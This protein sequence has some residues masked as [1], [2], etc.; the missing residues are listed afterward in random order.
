M[1]AVPQSL[2]DLVDL[3]DLERIDADLFRGRQPETSLQRVFGGQVAGQALAAA[4]R[5]VPPERAVHSL[6]AYFLLPGDPT[7]PIVYDVGHLRDGRSFTTRRVA[8]RQHGRVIF[9]VTASF[10]V[11]E[12]GYDHQDAMPEA[13]PPDQCQDLAEL[14][15][16]TSGA[17]RGLWHREWAA[18]DFR[19]VGDSTTAPELSSAE[20][21]ARARLWMRAA[22][23]LP[24]DPT[25]HA[26]V[27][28]YASDLT[29]LGAALVPHDTYLGAPG[30]QSAS[31]DHSMWFHRQFRADEWL[32][33]DQMAPSAYG[34][35]GLAIGRVFTAAGRLIATVAQEGLIRR[36][37]E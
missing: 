29:L 20:H 7:V 5:T 24:D 21:P 3:L 4:T 34:A 35:R 37:G 16:K 6:H 2:D 25:L 28:A 10:H 32:L 11:A 23:R 15:E 22:G 17:S 12:E 33:Y 13:P 9:N 27:L 1:P 19:F 14:F 18:M 30:M 26:C 36:I 8:A 31:L